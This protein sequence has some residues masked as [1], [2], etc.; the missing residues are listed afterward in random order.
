[1]PFISVVIPLWNK[2]AFIGDTLQ[3]VLGQTHRDFEVI[4]VNDGSTDGGE[5]VVHSFK[6][7]RIRLINQENSG[8]SAARNR[9]VTAARGDLIAFIDADDLW[10]PTFLETVLHLYEMFPQA[11]LFATGYKLRMPDGR[12]RRP[13]FTNMPAPPWEGILH[14]Y[15]RAAMSHNP[16]IMPSAAM[17]PK[18][19]LQRVMFAEG[20]FLE[21]I[22]LWPRIAFQYPIAWS[23]RVE[24]VYRRDAT[25]SDLKS[26][27]ITR[28]L[29]VIETLR[30]GLLQH[31]HLPGKDIENL[32]GKY[33]KFSATFYARNRDRANSLRCIRQ[34]IRYSRGAGLVKAAVLGL[35]YLLP[36]TIWETTRS[37]HS[38]YYD[39]FFRSK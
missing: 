25:N 37:A 16:V 26:H 4:V 12:F 27:R 39:I 20:E 2:K 3:S 30:Q 17:M 6:D 22:E 1:M 15:F 9:G 38:L 19:T 35:L 5:D 36:F 32:I 8:Q 24:V 31:P 33:Y 29:K 23:S 13:D 34:A 14:N 21:D 11:G 18:K 28:D 10:E 7:P